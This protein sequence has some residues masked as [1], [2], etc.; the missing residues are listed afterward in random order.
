MVQFLSKLVRRQR[1]AKPDRILV[2]AFDKP[3]ASIARNKEAVLDVSCVFFEVL[4][5]MGPVRQAPCC[6]PLRK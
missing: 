5:R 2:I 4:G 1:S 6:L 3:L